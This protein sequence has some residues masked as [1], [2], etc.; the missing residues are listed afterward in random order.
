MSSCIHFNIP[1]LYYFLMPLYY[2]SHKSDQEKEP[3]AFKEKMPYVNRINHQNRQQNYPLQRNVT[4]T[5]LWMY[6]R[7]KTLFYPKLLHNQCKCIHPI[8]KIS[9]QSCFWHLF[10]PGR[11]ANYYFSLQP[12][13][14]NAA[15]K[16]MPF[17]TI[18][19]GLFHYEQNPG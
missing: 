7:K 14:T 10:K 13:E 2:N 3:S 6:D 12:S 4:L 15:S 11:K 5:L 9:S 19:R 16:N 18:S 8:L 1:I 17:I